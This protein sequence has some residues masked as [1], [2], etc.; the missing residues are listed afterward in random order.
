M[1]SRV[2]D[3]HPFMNHDEQQ[4]Q[5]AT[6]T[7][8]FLLSFV[9]VCMSKTADCISHLSQ[10]PYN[11]VHSPEVKHNNRSWTKIFFFLAV[12]VL[13]QTKWAVPGFGDLDKIQKLTHISTHTHARTHAIKHACRYCNQCFIF[14]HAISLMHRQVL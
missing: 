2:S 4:N 6:Y 12:S 9:A 11:D 5:Q 13:P 14:S 3:S 7:V 10:H 1:P 8:I